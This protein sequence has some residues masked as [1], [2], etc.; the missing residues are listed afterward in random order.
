MKKILILASLLLVGMTGFSSKTDEVIIPDQAIRFRVIAASNTPE[1]QQIKQKVKTALQTDITNLLQDSESITDTRNSLKGNIRR[2]ENV[3]STTLLQNEEAT[4][5]DIH[6]GLNY[7]PEKLYKGVTYPAGYYESLVVTLGAGAGDNW[8]CV[9]F[10]PLCL[11][12]AEETNTDDIE[13]KSF[14]QEMIE[15]YF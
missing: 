9:L 6:Y 4:I 2:F 14:V 13:Y 1:D 12:E 15:K 5:F 11:L 10:P 7:F 3:V 8:W